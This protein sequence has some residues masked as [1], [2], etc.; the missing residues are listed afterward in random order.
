MTQTGRGVTWTAHL[1]LAQAVQFLEAVAQSE[2][3]PHLEPHVGWSGLGV[4]DAV[5]IGATD[6]PGAPVLG[7]VGQACSCVTDSV[8]VH[9]C[10]PPN[11][12]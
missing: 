3:L 5:V 6:V 12:H 7:K 1:P 8:V 4:G 10:S 9:P 11:T 2:S